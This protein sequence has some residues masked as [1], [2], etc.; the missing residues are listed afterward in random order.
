MK[1]IASALFL[2]L[3]LATA[4]TAQAGSPQILKC[5]TVSGDPLVYG[6]GGSTMGSLLG[7][8]LEK[9]FEEHK[10]DF[11][12]W[13]KASTGLARPDFHDWPKETPGIMKKHHPAVVVVSLGTNDYQP[14]W[15]GKGEWIQ[16]DDPKWETEYGDRVDAL[17]HAIADDDDDRLIIWSGPYAFEGDN[18][19]KRAP[20]VN[21]IMRERVEAYAQ[22]G[23]HA[24][25]QDA[26]GPTADDDGKPLKEAVL[27]PKG[28]KAVKIRS[29]DGIHL[30]ADAVRALL[31]QPIVDMVMPCFAKKDA[32]KPAAKGGSKTASKTEKSESESAPQ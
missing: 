4:T 6:I 20:I 3:G 11:R 29:K 5:P 9:V 10:V 16:Q 18:A 14:L 21:R 19:E 1:M 24:I 31:A 30:T 7:P 32:K 8:M 23:G 13:G 2:A 28:K 22:A 27:A 25:F 17:L 12:R 15:V 26:Y